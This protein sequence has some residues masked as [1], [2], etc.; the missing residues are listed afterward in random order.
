VYPVVPVLWGNCQVLFA[1]SE[2]DA[3]YMNIFGAMVSVLQ[4]GL[5]C[6][7]SKIERTIVA[8]I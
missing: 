1:I 7:S 3:A 4:L 2:G 5:I 6:V 8:L